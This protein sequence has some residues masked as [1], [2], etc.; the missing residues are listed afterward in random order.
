MGL[1]EKIQGLPIGYSKAFYQ[2]KSYGITRMDFNN[3]RSIKVYAEELG[4]NDYISLNFYVTKT[5]EIIKPCEMEL[6]KIVHF[7][8]NVEL[9]NE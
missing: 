6:E 1:K 7:L 8:M 9:G 3:G 5:S 4:G 2:G